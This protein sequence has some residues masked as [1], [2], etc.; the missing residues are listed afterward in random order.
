M[1]IDKTLPDSYEGDDFYTQKK[2]S[3]V[4]LLGAGTYFRFA[5]GII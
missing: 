3:V 2:Y 1:E 5:S 4:I